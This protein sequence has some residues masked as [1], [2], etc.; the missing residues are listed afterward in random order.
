M[1]KSQ[2]YREIFV[3]IFVLGAFL[4]LLIVV[5]FFGRSQNILKTQ[6]EINGIFRSV[7]GLNPGADVLLA[8]VKVGS[9][10]NIT[11]AGGMGVRVDMDIDLDKRDKIRR[12]SVATIRTKGLM[13][14]TYVAITIGSPEE[15]VVSRGGTITTTEPFE[16]SQLLE[17]MRPTLGELRGL[18]HRSSLLVNKLGDSQTLLNELL[19]NMNAVTADLR[20]GKGTAGALLT[21]DTLYRKAVTLTETAQ[22]TMVTVKETSKSIQ[23]SVEHFP[24]VIRQGMATLESVK[25][26][27]D[28][29]T[30]TMKDA[31][32]LIFKLQDVVEEARPVVSHIRAS[33]EN[34]EQIT[35]RIGPLIQ[36]ATHGVEEARAVIRALG[37]TWF[38]KDYMPPLPPVEPIAVTGRDRAASE[39]D[40][41]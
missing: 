3:G 15:P 28:K 32:G 33:S 7:A 8:G 35:A 19:E 2:G 12:D 40:M 22:E 14:D 25:R 9:V 16:V 30:G 4:L 20:R 24:E 38:L 1:P 6:F 18:F 21:D 27:A 23:G 36:S 13:G 34:V 29:T 10:K 31:S 39:K 26:A 41:P 5:L 11:F 17:E 37:Q